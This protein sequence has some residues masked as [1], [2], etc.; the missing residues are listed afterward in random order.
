[1]AGDLDIAVTVSCS[2]WSEA[3]PE[4]ETLCR[5]AASAAFATAAHIRD[6]A[7][8]S[9]MLADDELVRTLNRDYRG[10]DGATN[11]LAFA[12]MEGDGSR[13]PAAPVMLGDVVIAYETAAGEAAA[14]GRALA[15]HLRHLV[16]HGML[17][18][19]GFDHL[20]DDQAADMEELEIRVLSG[21]GVADPYAEPAPGKEE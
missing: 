11:V 12:A 18:L 10:H 4:C 3:V 13:P 20:S 17:H 8:V 2:A 1:M 9:L 5:A 19:L 16:V 6:A 21:L 14:G 15:D 7:E